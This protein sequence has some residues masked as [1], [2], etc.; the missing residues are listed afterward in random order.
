MRNNQNASAAGSVLKAWVLKG[1]NQYVE[2][3]GKL[4]FLA[5]VFL[6]DDRTLHAVNN[7]LHVGVPDLSLFRC[8]ET[9]SIQGSKPLGILA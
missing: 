7:I 6:P 4:M 1:R 9:P 5:T 2:V 3:N 8:L